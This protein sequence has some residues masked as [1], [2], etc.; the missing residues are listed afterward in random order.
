MPEL[1]S[2]VNTQES[3]KERRIIIVLAEASENT[4]YK[5]IG[6]VNLK[7]DEMKVKK[8]ENLGMRDALIMD[9]KKVKVVSANYCIG[10][11]SGRLKCQFITEEELHDKQLHREQIAKVNKGSKNLK[12]EVRPQT[13][14]AAN[15]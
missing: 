13:R 4:G 3:I 6:A 2:P 14:E 5:Y 10:Y 12:E 8:L 7:L 11:F 15:N 1:Y 9:F